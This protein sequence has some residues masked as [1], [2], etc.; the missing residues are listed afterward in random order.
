VAHL[1]RWPEKMK[2]TIFSLAVLVCGCSRT[3]SVEPPRTQSE[4]AIKE[5]LRD[6]EL[7][8]LTPLRKRDSAPKSNFLS[9]QL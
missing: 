2:I 3:P 5:Q 8:L 7:S 4:Q 6:I 1:E 9:V